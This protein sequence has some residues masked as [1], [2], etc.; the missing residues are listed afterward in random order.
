MAEA[1]QVLKDL[2]KRWSVQVNSTAALAGAV[3]DAAAKDDKQR[4][5]DGREPLRRKPELRGL[6]TAEATPSIKLTPWEVLHTLGCATVLS[7]QGA[8]RG[9]A[10]HWGSLKYC[11]ALEGSSGR[12]MMLSEEGLNPTRHYKTVQ[13]GELGFGFALAVAERVVKKRYPDHSVSVVDADI[14]LQAG[15]ALVGKDV[16]RRDW[17]RLRPDFFL[18]A[19]KPGEPSKVIPVACK[20][21][22]GKTPYAYTQLASAS[23]QVEAVH[24][25]PWNET[26]V[27]ITS[28]ELLGQGGIIIHLLHAPGDGALTVAPDDP[29]ADADRA[30]DDLN[31]YPDVR[32]PAAD[33]EDDERVSGFQVLPA[34]YGWFRA[35]LVRAGAAGL[36]GFTGGGEPTAQY[37]TKRQGRRHFEGFTH[38]GTGIVQDVDHE[39]RGVTFIGTDHVF[40]LNGKRVEAFSGVAEDL[41]H[42]LRDGEVER[43]RQEAHALRSVWCS[44]RGTDDWDGPVSLREDGSVMAMRLLPDPPRKR[45]RRSGA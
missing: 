34:R 21:T 3:A 14:T 40:R 2:V 11:Q 29:A 41:F 10:E 36:M 33:G 39:I 45:R 7:R 9:L 20:G 17:I 5:E 26:P 42:P 37:L 15:W 6:P 38:A 4:R 28:T 25:G 12:Y 16:K 18:E 22:H 19:W 24:V 35:A 43:Y 32:I 30:L 13:S 44:A 8:G 27:L 23:A 1:A 31:V